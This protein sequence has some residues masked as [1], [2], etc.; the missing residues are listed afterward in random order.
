MKE[1]CWISF[2][3]ICWAASRNKVRLDD[4][5]IFREIINFR[6]PTRCPVNFESRFVDPSRRWAR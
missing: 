3:K 6:Y 4:N 1:L 5:E 2:A